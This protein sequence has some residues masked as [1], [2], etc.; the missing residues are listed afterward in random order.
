MRSDPEQ[1]AAGHDVTDTEASPP[2]A[3]SDSSTQESKDTE[4]RFSRDSTETDEGDYA[5]IGS[6][7]D[8]STDTLVFDVSQNDLDATYTE[9]SSRGASVEFDQATGAYIEYPNEASD[10]ESLKRS[11]SE[12]DYSSLGENDSFFVNFE[13]ELEKVEQQY[14]ELEAKHLLSEGGQEQEAEEGVVWVCEV[15][16]GSSTCFTIAEEVEEEENPVPQVGKLDS[17]MGQYYSSASG[18]DPSRG[19]ASGSLPSSPRSSEGWRMSMASTAT[20]ASS[21]TANSDDTLAK[22]MSELSSIN[23]RLSY[24]DEAHDDGKVP[25]LNQ[26]TDPDIIPKETLQPDQTRQTSIKDAI[27]ELESIEQAAQTLLLKR[28]CSDDERATPV[29]G[30]ACMAVD[31][32]QKVYENSNKSERHVGADKTESSFSPE[33]VHKNDRYTNEEKVSVNISEEKPPLPPTAGSQPPKVEVKR[34]WFSRSKEIQ[35]YISRESYNNDKIFKELERLRRSFQE[36]DLN[37]FL[38]TL[39]NTAIPD[40]MDEAFLRQLLLDIREDVEGPPPLAEGDAQLIE[41]AEIIESEAATP[42]PDVEAVAEVAPRQTATGS[43]FEKVKERILEM[44]KV[45]K[46]DKG[47]DG[48]DADTLNLQKDDSLSNELL[49]DDSSRSETPQISRSITPQSLRPETPDSKSSRPL[50][51]DSSKGDESKKGFNIAE[52]LKKGSPKYLR[53]KYKERKNRKSDVLTTSE[54]ESED[55]EGLRK[56]VN[57]SNNSSSTKKTILSDSQSSL[58]GSNRSLTASQELKKEVRFDLNTDTQKKGGDDS[59]N[60]KI[61]PVKPVIEDEKTKDSPRLSGPQMITCEAQQQETVILKEFEETTQEM[62]NDYILNLPSTVEDINARAENL[63]PRL[64]ERA[65]P[66][67]RRKKLIPAP[68]EELSTDVQS[69]TTSTTSVE[70]VKETRAESLKV[71]AALKDESPPPLPPYDEVTELETCTPTYIQVVETS[72][73]PEDIAEI[74]EEITESIE[75][76]ERRVKAPPP[77]A[78]TTSGSPATVI[79]EI[80]ILN[81]EASSSVASTTDSRNSDGLVDP[82]PVTSVATISVAPAPE[83]AVVVMYPPRTLP[84]PVIQESLNEDQVSL[85]TPSEPTLSF[86]T[87]TSSA[88]T[89]L[90]GDHNESFYDNANPFE[91]FIEEEKTLSLQPDTAE[92]T[93]ESES[94]AKPTIVETENKVEISETLELTNKDSTN[95][96]KTDLQK[97]SVDSQI[98]E[99]TPQISETHVGKVTTEIIPCES[100][101]EVAP[102]EVKV[103]DEKVFEAKPEAEPEAKAEEKPEAESE[104]KSEVKAEAKPDTKAEDKPETKTEET[105]RLITES[106]VIEETTESKSETTC[107]ATEIAEDTKDKLVTDSQQE[108]C[109]SPELEKKEIAD[110]DTLAALTAEMFRF[111]NEDESSKTR[112]QDKAFDSAVTRDRS[113]DTS[114]LAT[115]KDA[116]VSETR[117][118]QTQDMSTSTDTKEMVTQ[119]EQDASPRAKSV[120]E[121]VKSNTIAIQTDATRLVRMYEAASQTDTEYETDLETESELEENASGR[122]DASKWLFRPTND[123]KTMDPQMQELHKQQQMMIQELQQQSVMQQQKQKKAPEVPPRQFQ[124]KMPMQVVEE[125][126]SVLAENGDETTRLKKVADPPPRWDS[127]VTWENGRLTSSPTNVTLE[128]SKT[129]VTSKDASYFPADPKSFPDS[130]PNPV[131]QS[132]SLAT[133]N[134]HTKSERDGRL[135]RRPSYSVSTDDLAPIPEEAPE[136]SARAVG[137]VVDTRQAYAVEAEPAGVPPHAHQTAAGASDHVQQTSA[138]VSGVMHIPARDSHHKKQ[139]SASFSHLVQQAAAGASHNSQQTPAGASTHVQQ[140]TVSMQQTRDNIS[141]HNHQPPDR[142]A[143]TAAAAPG[144]VAANQQAADAQTTAKIRANVYPCFAPVPKLPRGKPPVPRPIRRLSA[145]GQEDG[146]LSDPGARRGNGR[147][148]QT[149]D[150]AKPPV[151]APAEDRGYATDSEVVVKAEGKKT[152]LGTWTPFGQPGRDPPPPPTTPAHG[153]ESVP[154]TPPTQPAPPVENLPP[155]PP[156]IPTHPSESAFDEPLTLPSPRMDRLTDVG[157]ATEGD[158][159]ANFD[160]LAGEDASRLHRLQELHRLYQQRRSYY[161]DKEA[162]IPP[163]D[164]S[165]SGPPQSPPATDK[166]TAP[167]ALPK[168]PSPPP[169]PPPPPPRPSPPPLPPPPPSDPSD[170]WFPAPATASADRSVATVE[171]LYPCQPARA[172]SGYTTDPEL[173]YRSDPPRRPLTW[174]PQ[175]TLPVFPYLDDGGATTAPRTQDSVLAEGSSNSV[176]DLS[177]DLPENPSRDTDPAK[178]VGG[179]GSQRLQAQGLG[180]WLFFARLDRTN[181]LLSQL[182]T[183]MELRPGTQVNGSSDVNGGQEAAEDTRRDSQDTICRND[184]VKSAKYPAGEQKRGHSSSPPPPPRPRTPIDERDPELVYAERRYLSYFQEPPFKQSKRSAVPHEPEISYQQLEAQRRYNNYFVGPPRASTPSENESVKSVELD[185]AQLAAQR[186]YQAYFEPGPPKPRARRTPERQPEP[187]PEQLEAEKRFLSYFNAGPPRTRPSSQTERTPEPD[188]EQLE[189][190]RRYLAYF[191]PGPP[192][193]RTSSQTERTPEPDAQQLE[194]EKRYLSYFNPGPPRPRPRSE[195]YDNVTEPDERQREAEK[196]YLAYFQGTPKAKHAKDEEKEEKGGLRIPPTRAMLEAEERF[197]N[198]FKPVPCGEP[199][200]LIEPPVSDS[201]RARQQLMKEYWKALETRV[202][203]KEKKIIKVSK[204]KREVEREATPPTQREL[205]VEEFLKRVKDRKKEKDLHFGDTDDEDEE[206]TAKKTLDLKL[207]VPPAP[208][209]EPTTPTIEGGGEISSRVANDLDLFVSKEGECR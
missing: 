200:R 196:R 111:A 96:E 23:S 61:E 116:A 70:S 56:D 173:S 71:N 58:K 15:V 177:T 46:K 95:L 114:D 83:T 171:S 4:R 170:T 103:D 90:E 122:Y 201:D 132:Q 204:P 142:P 206:S 52:F 54:S 176:G 38:D 117:K 47:K 64:P 93:V 157:Q 190:E 108:A 203:R 97:D 37:D 63:L 124:Q 208:V 81:S 163:Y 151:Q 25:S 11:Q 51:P 30:D 150:R 141:H 43:K 133:E 13:E 44:I 1:G 9:E 36:S 32:T 82:I 164:P 186:R 137:G 146:Y 167:A 57:Y 178:Q 35:P 181:K 88:T 175:S 149:P 72:R 158:A 76:T 42:V 107:E 73:H 136:P 127:D 2:K 145:D 153:K 99:V 184:I 125:L 105:E 86:S 100:F 168:S 33:N 109:K 10:D 195:S 135:D 131:T 14:P 174:C 194:A 112:K 165:A 75:I 144:N 187:D 205:V 160:H 79:N 188:A 84:L 102:G 101:E 50:T 41:D 115:Q 113:D 21:A 98:I 126:K 159:G 191:N 172:H 161:D 198:Y 94:P 207:G 148:R 143:E 74:V 147:L 12:E 80:I 179:Y 48:D 3:E 199:R 197:L 123:A 29:P 26:N 60:A 156:P 78:V 68:V 31:S 140:S 22:D 166:E 65:K 152:L 5:E 6:Q 67:R 134:A 19:D 106:S 20:V 155:A 91:E 138:D 130:F 183:T 34:R 49:K 62:E 39:E 85:P 24:L 17:T 77:P 104:T 66:P 119:T 121:M 118:A 162:P 53:K 110:I 16:E 192:R 8:T 169:I 202:E 120:K 139:S 209:A 18:G 45:R 28:Q 182:P 128:T 154:L 185:E 27:D 193:P 129:L 69:E 59:K 180:E 7:T 189:A 40:D 89:P 55:A 87:L 92:A